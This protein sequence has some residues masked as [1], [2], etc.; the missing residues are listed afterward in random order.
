MDWTERQKRTVWNRATIVDGY[1]PNQYRKD[2]CGAWIEWGEY[3]NNQNDFGWEIDHIFPQSLLE[4]LNVP[5]DEMHDLKNLRAMHH[6]NNASKG[7][8]YPHY[9]ACVIADGNKNIRTSRKMEINKRV[10][11]SIN[12]LYWWYMMD[13]EDIDYDI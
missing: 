11:E 4:Q 12:T 6:S 2:C 8:D 10:Q 3:G 7:D 5:V 1:N 9:T 13:D